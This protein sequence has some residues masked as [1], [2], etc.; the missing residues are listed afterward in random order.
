MDRLIALVGL[1]WRLDARA[2]AGSRGRLALLLIALPPLLV[3]SA[4]SAFVAFAGARF[5]ERAE[6]DLLL[7]AVSALAT[8][9]GV[10]WALAPLLAGI[11]AT[12]THDMGK[13]LSYPVSLPVLVVSSLVANLL[14]PIVLAQ[15]PPLVALALGLGG[16]GVRATPLLSQ[17]QRMAYT[18]AVVM[19]SAVCY[20]MYQREPRPML[21]RSILLS[22]SPARH[23]EIIECFR[24][25][26]VQMR[27]KFKFRRRARPI[28]QIAQHQPEVQVRPREVWFQIDRLHKFISRLF[29]QAAPHVERPQIVMRQRHPRLE[30]QRRPVRRLRR[31][32]FAALLVHP[33]QVIIRVRQARLVRDRRLIFSLRFVNA[34]LPCQRQAQ[35]VVP[36]PVR[37]C[38]S[39]CFTEFCNGRRIIARVKSGRATPIQVL[40]A[41]PVLRDPRRIDGRRRTRHSILWRGEFRERDQSHH[42]RQHHV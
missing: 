9:L 19:L 2:V 33:A 17:L 36:T 40:R 3:V 16:I 32:E 11:A 39:Q 37:G 26:A 42:H 6:P 23:S 22:D 24:R 34:P 38:Q 4:V 12:E 14:Q 35:A 1:R 8:L 28:R 5:L 15:A 25:L 21:P 41:H 10:G 13:L 29:F 31:V 30:R 27:H 7:P 18:A 20:R